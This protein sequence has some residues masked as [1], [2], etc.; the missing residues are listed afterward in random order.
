MT[1][2]SMYSHEFWFRLS[3][4]TVIILFIVS[5]FYENHELKY[6]SSVFRVLLQV[7][8]CV[9]LIWRFRPFRKQKTC[10]AFDQSVAF[11]TGAVLL[12]TYVL[13]AAYQSIYA[14]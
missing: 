1:S 12:F 6:F 9:F 11:E 3:S 13:N 4:L 5:F 8:M 10:N 2:T 14:Q 7:Y